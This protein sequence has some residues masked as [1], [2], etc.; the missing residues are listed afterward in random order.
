M[1]P[2]TTT[3]A[4][5]EPMTNT[6]RTLP[7]SPT[8]SILFVCLGN[9]C[10]SPAGENMMRK[11]LQDAGLSSVVQCDS[12]GISGYHH[13]DPPDARM[14]AAGQQRGLPMTGNARQVTRQDI[15]RF[16]L[17]L[18]MDNDN[19]AGLMR[20][21]TSHNRHKVRMFCDYCTRHDE[22]EVP[23]PY[24][25]GPDGFEHVLNIMEDGCQE[26]LRLLRA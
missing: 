20:L 23:D 22:R 11:L 3:T 13:G 16:D 8:R 19:H 10:R 2:T 26:I 14:I 24:Y 1:I 18:A 4:V 6:A 5:T 15:D 12:A 25:G 21:V 17:I 7:V 9:I